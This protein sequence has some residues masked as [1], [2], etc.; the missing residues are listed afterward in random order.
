[1]SVTI[2]LT[3]YFTVKLPE[4]YQK[5]IDKLIEKHGFASRADVIKDA[6]R[7]FFE[8]YPETKVLLTQ[9]EEV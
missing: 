9:P 3:E 5:E 4:C 7:D 8:K 6:L 2:R 1:M